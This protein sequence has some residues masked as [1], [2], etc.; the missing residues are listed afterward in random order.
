MKDLIIDLSSQSEASR[1]EELK[2]IEQRIKKAKI[3][4]I[5]LGSGHE[6]PSK[7]KEV[8]VSTIKVDNALDNKKVYALDIRITKIEI[9]HTE[10]NVNFRLICKPSIFNTL[11]IFNDEEYFSPI[12]WYDLDY[13]QRINF[14]DMFS[15]HYREC[16]WSIAKAL[17]GVHIKW[18]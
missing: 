11:K 6:M 9:C 16:Y 5:A 12:G 7:V 10:Y 17:K 14:I 1:Q 4:K 13:L 3:V 18:H 8:T 15:N 2:K